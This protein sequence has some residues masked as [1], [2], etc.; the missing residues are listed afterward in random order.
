MKDTTSGGLVDFKENVIFEKEKETSFR[1]S[2]YFKNKMKDKYKLSDEQVSKLYIRI[3]KYQVK[4][5]GSNLSGAFVS[6]PLVIKRTDNVFKSKIRR[7]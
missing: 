6:K 1:S 3:V 4:K 7:K 5:Y 2:E